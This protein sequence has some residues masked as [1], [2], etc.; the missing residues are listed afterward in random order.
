MVLH[1]LGNH[2]DASILSRLDSALTL[3]EDYVWLENVLS[4]LNNSS[5]LRTSLAVS[6]LLLQVSDSASVSSNL[7][8]LSVVVSTELVD[9]SVQTINLGLVAELSN[10]EVVSTVAVTEL[11]VNI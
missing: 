5:C 2:L 6:E 8:V 1:V 11:V 3:T 9:L 10:S 4:L 7:T